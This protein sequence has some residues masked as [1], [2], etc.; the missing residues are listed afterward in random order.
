MSCSVCRCPC[1]TPAE[2]ERHLDAQHQHVQKELGRLEAEVRKLKQQTGELEKLQRELREANARKDQQSNHRYDV[3]DGVSYQD[4][5]ALRSDL[6]A[7]RREVAE[8]NAQVAEQFAKEIREVRAGLADA[9][10]GRLAGGNNDRRACSDDDRRERAK[11]WDELEEVKQVLAE[12]VTLG[13]GGRGKSSPDL[14]P[15]G[16]SR[17][18]RELVADFENKPEREQE[19]LLLVMLSHV[20]AMLTLSPPRVLVDVLREQD[21]SAVFF[22]SCGVTI[23]RSVGTFL[24]AVLLI[25]M[26]PALFSRYIEPLDCE[27]DG[28]WPRACLFEDFAKGMNIFACGPLFVA[29]LMSLTGLL[30]G[31]FLAVD[32]CVTACCCDCCRTGFASARRWGVGLL[33]NLFFYWLRRKLSDA[34]FPGFDFFAAVSLSY[35]FLVAGLASLALLRGQAELGIPAAFI[36]GEVY[37]AVLNLLLTPSSLER[38]IVDAELSRGRPT[39]FWDRLREANGSCFAITT[40]EARALRIVVWPWWCEQDSAWAPTVPRHITKVYLTDVRRSITWDGL[41][42]CPWMSSRRLAFGGRR[43]YVGLSSVDDREGRRRNDSSEPILGIYGAWPDGADRARSLQRTGYEQSDEEALRTLSPR[44]GDA[45]G[46]GLSLTPI[47]SDRGG[48]AYGSDGRR[49]RDRDR[50][51]ADRDTS[52]GRRRGE[53]RRDRDFDRDLDRDRRR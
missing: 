44:D 48:G 7:Q 3:G 52:D 34:H 31:T 10:G 6:D 36:L 26:L 21:L 29:I 27:A 32:L 15:R 28:A 22:G 47:D 45:P 18:E 33:F 39:R 30:V 42:H 5:A 1:A 12:V 25:A 4:I 37:C 11:I 38:T 17:L 51:R 43:G 49:D 2:V 50:G 9:K 53:A 46:R 24:A 13:D 16:A 23:C 41:Q 40:T 14:S 20:H 35:V 8:A 19:Q